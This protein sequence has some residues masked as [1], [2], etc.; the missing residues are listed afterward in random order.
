[1]TP[2]LVVS[3]GEAML[4]LLENFKAISH[5]SED[6]IFKKKLTFRAK[7]HIISMNEQ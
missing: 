6:G 1:M 5:T 2:K 4:L 7:G 3:T